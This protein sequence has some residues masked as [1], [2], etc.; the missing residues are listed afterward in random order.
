M[1]LDQKSCIPCQGGVLP[2]NGTESGAYLENLDGWEL[3]NDGKAI[4]KH[5]EFK[6]FALSLDFVNK[7]G[8]IAEKEKHHPDIEF[9]WGYCDIT[10]TTHKIDGLHENDFILAAK[11]DAI[12]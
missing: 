2:L 6:N 3:I 7:I 12:T 1:G 4:K 10:V 5:V 8:E 11:I 9:G